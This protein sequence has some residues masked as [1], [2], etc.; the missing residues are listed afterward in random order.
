MLSRLETSIEMSDLSIEL[1]AK[2]REGQAQPGTAPPE[3]EAQ[4]VVKRSEIQEEREYLLDRTRAMAEELAHRPN[5]GLQTAPKRELERCGELGLL[6]ACLPVDDGGLG[7]GLEPGTQS[8]LLRLLSAVGGADLALG[9]LLEGHI[10]GL[11]L[12]NKYGSA[13]QKHRLAED[14]HNGMLSGVWNTGAPELL[15]LQPDGPGYRFEGVKTFATGAAFVRRPI[16]TAD[17]PGRGWQMTVPRMEVLNPAID[18]SFWHPLGMES[19]ESFGVDFT[20]GMVRDADLI[21]QPG[22]FYRDPMFR[23][24]AIRFAAVQ[25]GAVLRL[26]V[27]FAE[28]LEEM[29]RGEDPYQIVRLG[30]VAIAAQEAVLWVEKAAAVAEECFFRED[31]PHVDRMIECANMMRVAIERL[32]TLVMQKVTAGVGAHGLLQPQRFE[33]VI[34]DLTMYLRQPAPDA[35][36]AAVGK[37]SLGKLHGRTDACADGFWS[38]ERREES[39][40]PRYFRNVYQRKRDPWGFES[41]EY[42]RNKY[43]ET[44]RAL[45]D[46]RYRCGLEVGCSIGVLTRRLAERADDLLGLDVSERALEQARARCAELEHV[47]FERRRVP[48]DM[49]DGEFDLMVISEVAYYWTQ[50]DLERAASALAGKHRA[51]GHLILVHLTE[52]VPDYPQTGDQVHDYWLSRPEWTRVRGQRFERYR[53]DV[54]ERVDS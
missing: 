34:R 17:L 52:F 10:N 25:A 51:G 24:G 33:R 5:L 11:L 50:R 14:V 1:N 7:I 45:P 39:L 36:L 48:F 44:L 53:L 3:R 28:W 15:R 41:S 26:H 23:G 22:D 8:M 18:R 30:D 40:P 19:S 37:A 32:A 42:E 27:L 2:I 9:R 12:V 54:L 31:K 13:E 29:R 46:A 43:E 16:V 6:A 47:R 4:R 20:G 49:P 35:T 21:G 38:G